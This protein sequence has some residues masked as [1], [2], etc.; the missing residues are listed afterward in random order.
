MHLT[1]LLLSTFL[2]TVGMTTGVQ[3]LAEEKPATAPAPSLVQEN[4]PTPPPAHHSAD[5]PSDRSSDR[6]GT[7]NEEP[8]EKTSSGVEDWKGK[9]DD[10]QM[11]F[12]GLTGLGIIDQWVGYAILGTVSK[13]VAS[14]GFIPNI[15][16]PLWIELEL[17]AVFLSPGTAF[18]YAAQMR[19]DFIKDTTWTLYALGGVG[20]NYLNPTPA[21]SLVS[22]SRT[23]FAPRF[24]V[25]GLLNV[26]STVQLRGEITHDLIAVGVNVPM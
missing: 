8:Q 15:N 25:G 17:G 14:S 3:A 24:G 26:T 11:G 1:K 10:T 20:G 21:N 4:G 2:L 6:S 18:A 19:W 16:N 5:H 23:E 13:K 9:P 22:L 7:K 12:G